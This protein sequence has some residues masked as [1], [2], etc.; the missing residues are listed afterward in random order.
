MS[1]RPASR[2]ATLGRTL[3]GLR[4]ALCQLRVVPGR[5]DRNVEAILREIAAAEERHGAAL[6]RML[7]LYR[8]ADPTSGYAIGRFPTMQKLYDDLVAKGSASRAAAVYFSTTPDC[9]TPSAAV[10]SSRISTRAPK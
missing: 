8:I 1:P 7:T 9:F 4:V 3:E 10:G 2:S 5:P 6:E